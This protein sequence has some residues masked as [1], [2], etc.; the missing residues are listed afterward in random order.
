[1]SGCLGAPDERLE[2]KE[3]RIAELEDRLEELEQE[4][5]RLTHEAKPFKKG[6]EDS[7]MK[8]ITK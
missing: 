8:D 5:F 7:T 6:A 3:L 1:M 4:N 2:E